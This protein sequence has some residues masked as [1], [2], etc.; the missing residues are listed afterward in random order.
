MCYNII[1]VKETQRQLKE[2]LN[3]MYRVCL[4]KN[5][6]C[7]NLYA[8]FYFSSI[9]RAKSVMM[10]WGFKDYQYVVVKVSRNGAVSII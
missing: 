1:T 9:D 2:R 8:G 10:S 5:N 4:K 7:F 6:G 3:I